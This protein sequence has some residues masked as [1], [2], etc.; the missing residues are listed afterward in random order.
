MRRGMLGGIT[1]PFGVWVRL[2]PQ[3]ERGFGGWGGIVLGVVPY[4]S[5]ESLDYSN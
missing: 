2:I 1:M 5:A 3:R 4:I